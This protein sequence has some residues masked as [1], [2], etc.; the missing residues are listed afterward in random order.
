VTVKILH[1]TAELSPFVRTGGLGDAAGGLAR[2]LAR[3]GHEVTVAVPAYADLSPF[4]LHVPGGEDRTWVELEDDILTVLARR[5][6]DAFD[7]PGVYGPTPGSAYDDN[8]WRYGRFAA[9]VAELAGDFDLVHL[10]DPHAG[11]AAMLIERPTVY[12]IHNASHHLLGPFDE[13]AALLGVDGDRALDMEWYGRANYLKAGI[14]AADRVTTVSHSHASELGAEETSF[15]L[16]GVVASIDH[17]ISGILNGIDAT[18]W[19]PEADDVLPAE[20]NV[21]DMSG[22][23]KVRGALLDDTGLE[24][25]MVFGNVGRMARQKGLDLLDPIIGHLVDRGMRLI[26]IGNGEL[27]VMVDGWVDEHPGR[28]IHLPY[29]EEWAR[30]VSAGA[31]AYL[32][33]SE[34]EP[35]GL[36]QIYA[37]RYGAPPIVHMTGGLADSVVDLDADPARATGFGYTDHSAAG[38]EAAIVRAMDVFGQDRETWRWLQHNGMS[39][40]WSW[41]ARSEEYLAVYDA[42]SGTGR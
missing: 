41:A 20:F 18:L 28:I 15:G 36:G 9:A 3:K 6:D 33:P 1:A 40:D 22:R 8:W 11:A 13:A 27:D 38:L 39:I 34:F 14:V 35:C 24:D 26:L 25:G 31:D 37:M 19:N 21:H 16:A 32:M 7:R 17:P 23:A 4:G 2:A 10:H 30:L 5:D 42:A 12:T 29:S